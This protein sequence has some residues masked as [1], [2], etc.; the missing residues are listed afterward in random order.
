MKKINITLLTTLIF[1]FFLTSCQGIKDGLSGAKSEN[2]DE[3]LVQKKNPLVTPPDYLKL[4]KPKDQDLTGESK[5]IE[6][7][8]DI[9][10]ILKINK[11]SNEIS[12]DKFESAEKFVLEN[13]K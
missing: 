10:K 1:A 2:S 6:E 4:P 5:I 11:D 8:T 7:E 9:Q 12:K 3:F 13:I